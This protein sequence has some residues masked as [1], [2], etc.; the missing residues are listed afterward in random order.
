M[1]KPAARRVEAE[2]AET[3]NAKETMQDPYRNLALNGGT[4]ECLRIHG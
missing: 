4:V 2:F 3:I 1:E